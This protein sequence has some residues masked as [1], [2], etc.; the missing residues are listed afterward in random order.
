MKRILY[1]LLRITKSLSD[2]M[3]LWIILISFCSVITILALTIFLVT[4]II[5]MEVYGTLII[6]GLLLIMGL[7]AWRQMFHNIVA[8]NY[9][10]NGIKKDLEVALAIIEKEK[11]EVCQQKKEV[12][13]MAMKAGLSDEIQFQVKDE[14]KHLKEFAGQTKTSLFKMADS[15]DIELQENIQKITTQTEK[16][17]D[18][19]AKLAESSKTVG[20]KS[21]AVADGAAQALDN[22]THVQQSAEG[23]SAAV[24]VITHQMKQTKKLT[25]DAVSISNDTQQTIAG[26]EEA[27]RGIEDIIGLINNI[28]RQTNLLALNATIE[29]ARAGEA[30]KGFAVV[31]SEV[32]ELACQTTQSIDQITDHIKG[33]Q[34]KVGN[35]VMGI[36][37][38]KTSI[39]DVQSSADIIGKEVARQGVATKEITA[40]I[41]E[42]RSSVQTVTNGVQDISQEANSNVNIVGEINEI[43]EELVVQVLSIRNHML[44]IVQNAL[45]D[46]ER[47]S[48]ERF[49][50]RTPSIITIDGHHEE[51]AVQVID[52]SMGG[53]QLK[54]QNTLPP[55]VSKRGKISTG[56]GSTI[57]FNIRNMQDGIINAQFD[58]DEDLI[59]MFN[60]HLNGQSTEDETNDLLDDVELFG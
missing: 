50:A 23:L 18:V 45:D 6:C 1:P 25:E 14:L 35:A 30:G 20:D 38:I 54:T 42:A 46:N 22:T 12:R 29:A 3:N 41:M 43:S 8:A 16:A 44:E 4:P 5:S 17:N 52:Y 31:A 21:G 26:L 60:L 36:D 34:N 56:E 55:I 32:K 11:D 39:D 27:A 2:Q 49:S 51:I 58:D 19:A 57:D 47:R 53:M 10:S 40:S 48:T 9:I 37:L 33:I 13:K 15:I 59:R 7:I 28:A 24:D